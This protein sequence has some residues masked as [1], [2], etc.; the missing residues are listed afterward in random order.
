MS[1]LAAVAAVPKIAK[2]GL[3][4]RG[5]DSGPSRRLVLST[6]RTSLWASTT[7][8]LPVTFK[9]VPLDMVDFLVLCRMRRIRTVFPIDLSNIEF[10]FGVSSS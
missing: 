8:L 6:L 4:W 7:A 2:D 9:R 1:E 5:I 10:Q 3:N